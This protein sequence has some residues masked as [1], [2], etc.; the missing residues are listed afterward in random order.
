MQKADD[1][2]KIKIET[3]SRIPTKEVVISG[4]WIEILQV[5]FDL[6]TGSTSPKTKL[7]YDAGVAI[8]KMAMTS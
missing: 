4:P 3:G 7:N 1:D 5:D 8:L 6:H 2:P